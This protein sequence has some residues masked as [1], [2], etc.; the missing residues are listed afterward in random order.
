VAIRYATISGNWSNPLIWDGALTVPTLGDD[1]YSNN[2][3]V[4]IDVDINV[5]TLRNTSNVSPAITA[6]GQFVV[7]GSSGTRNITLTNASQG[8]ISAGS[9]VTNCALLINSTAGMTVNLNTTMSAALGAFYTFINGNCLLNLVGNMTNITN[10]GLS[11]TALAAGGTT[12]YIGTVISNGLDSVGFASGCIS[13]TFNTTGGI[14]SSGGFLRSQATGFTYNQTGSI[15]VSSGGGLISLAAGANYTITGNV[16]STGTSASV[17]ITSASSGNITVNGNVT[18]AAA[19]QAIENLNATSLTTITGNIVNTGNRMALQV[20][21]LR[22]SPSAA[23]TITIGDTSGG[24]RIFY[25]NNFANYP[26]VTDVRSGVVYSSGALTGTCAVPP[27]LSVA[28]GVP[29]DN[30]T[31][32]SII[33]RA[34]LITDV[35]AIVAAYPT[36]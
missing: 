11:Y 22:V 35:G 10:A 13:Y 15:S 16:T 8:V 14:T 26:A 3:T 32:L 6:L 31:G 25:A 33:T 18:G 12:N 19:S 21:N 5:A 28:F 36:T 20:S 17:F 9:L 4:T 1:V 29:V 23:Q 30:T 2:R 27:A 34:Q 24:S 7:S